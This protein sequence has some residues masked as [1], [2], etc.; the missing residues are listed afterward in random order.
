[1]TQDKEPPMTKVPPIK[2]RGGRPKTPGG[3]LPRIAVKLSQEWIDAI[4][5]EAN[6]LGIDRSAV[7]RGLI[8]ARFRESKQR[9]NKHETAR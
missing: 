6:R 5:A 1:M 8:V 2:N 4:D 7:V 3:P 9:K